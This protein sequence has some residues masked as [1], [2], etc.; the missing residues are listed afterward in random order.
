M[1]KRSS[2]Q[3]ATELYYTCNTMWLTHRTR[4]VAKKN[5]VKLLA[6]SKLSTRKGVLNH[7][8]KSWVHI[9]STLEKNLVHL[10]RIP[11]L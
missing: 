1:F 9:K 2:A 4:R 5:G 11:T 3:Q 7:N 8:D 10:P 6:K